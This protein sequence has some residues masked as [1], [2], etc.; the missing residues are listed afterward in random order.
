MT[1]NDAQL[2][3]ERVL[4]ELDSLGYSDR[5]KRMA[6]LG[7]QHKG[8]AGYSTLLATLLAVPPMRHIWL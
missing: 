8:E 7:V 4:K 2:D 1:Y 6:S 5:M 3:K